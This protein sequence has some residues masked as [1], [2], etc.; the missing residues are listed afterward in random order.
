M[1]CPRNNEDK[2]YVYKDVRNEVE[3]CEVHLAEFSRFI[4][5]QI[6]EQVRP[7]K[8]NVASNFGYVILQVS[9]R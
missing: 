2:L 1:K 9:V 5:F 7:H 6:F 3:S 4:K 8:V